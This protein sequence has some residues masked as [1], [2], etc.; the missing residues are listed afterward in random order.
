MGK[1]DIKITY[2]DHLWRFIKMKM[3]DPTS[4]SLNYHP[5][6]ISHASFYGIVIGKMMKAVLA[7]DQRTKC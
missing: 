4:H 1:K 6:C 7:S 3:L 2:L 5:P